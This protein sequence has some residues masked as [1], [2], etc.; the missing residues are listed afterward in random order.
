MINLK[1]SFTCIIR[2][3]HPFF[4]SS[5]RYVYMWNLESYAATDFIKRS[6][7]FRTVWTPQFFL[8]PPDYF[9]FHQKD[10]IRQ[11]SHCFDYISCK[12]RRTDN[13][14]W[15]KYSYIIIHLQYKRC[16]I[17]IYE[18]MQVPRRVPDHLRRLQGGLLVAQDEHAR[19]RTGTGS[20]VIH[21]R[22]FLVT[23]KPVL[24]ILIRFGSGSASMK[25]ILIRVAKNQPKS[26]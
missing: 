16:I 2:N 5:K 6:K 10:L 19:G 11:G 15:K 13:M 9:Y 25:R 8:G 1:L 4:I 23:C 7:V 21:G 14:I 12:G 26:W 3:Y 17:Y 20:L 24:R 22:V 18:L